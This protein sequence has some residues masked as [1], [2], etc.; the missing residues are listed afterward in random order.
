MTVSLLILTI[1][2]V[3]IAFLLC[4]VVDLAQVKPPMN[5]I[6]KI[7]IILIA[8]LIVLRQMAIV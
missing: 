6:L 2:I 7:A 1:V 5:T 4:Y 3:I 8:V